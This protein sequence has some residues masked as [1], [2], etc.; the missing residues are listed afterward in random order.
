MVELRKR[1]TP[2]PAP[3]KPAKKATKAKAPAKDEDVAQKA[4][5]KAKP[6]PKP[7]A[8]SNEKPAPAKSKTASGPAKTGDEVDFE[9]FGGEIET[10]DGEKTTLKALVEKSKAGVILFT[11][12]KAS[13]PGC[14]IALMPSCSSSILIWV[15]Q[16][17]TKHA[18]SAIRTRHSRRPVWISMA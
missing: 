15:Y 10:N 13:T 7:A 14:K 1:K 6:A 17:R 11:Y 8:K 3:P 12:P 18:C 2:P 9:G 16:A 4:E 5:P